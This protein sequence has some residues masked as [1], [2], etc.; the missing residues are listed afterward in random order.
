MLDYGFTGD[1]GFAV[2]NRTDRTAAYAYPSSPNALAA[3]RDPKGT[4]ERMLPQR[5]PCHAD[6]DLFQRM[7]SALYMARR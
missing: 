7:T 3:K 5:P 6:E 2:V 4:A 1:G